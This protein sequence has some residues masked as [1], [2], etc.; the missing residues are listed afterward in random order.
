MGPR[1]YDIPSPDAAALP[2]SRV[3]NVDRGEGLAVT[4]E[5]RGRYK[6]RMPLVARSTRKAGSCS[7]AAARAP[8]ASGSGH[9]R[10]MARRR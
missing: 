7:M 4:G 2:A 10:G 8:R 9:S 1:L 3:L 5:L 6:I